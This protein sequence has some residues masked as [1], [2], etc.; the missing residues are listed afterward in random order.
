MFSDS[1][2]FRRERYKCPTRRLTGRDPGRTASPTDPKTAAA[3]FKKGCSV[4]LARRSTNP[5]E[6][7]R[8]RSLEKSASYPKTYLSALYMFP[9]RGP[10]GSVFRTRNTPV[11]VELRFYYAFR[12]LTH[13]L[14]SDGTSLTAKLGTPWHSCTAPDTADPARRTNLGSR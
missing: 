1:A 7:P 12:F 2:T 4:T 8:E 6:S 5:Q 13:F 10:R 9:Q 11:K 3:G 14:V